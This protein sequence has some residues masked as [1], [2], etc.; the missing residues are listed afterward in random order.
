MSI[1]SPIFAFRFTR[2]ADQ[3]YRGLKQPASKVDVVYPKPTGA[4]VTLL[5]QD[6]TSWMRA[7]RTKFILEERLPA[8]T[9]YE[10]FAKKFVA[11][12]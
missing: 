12:V 3:S 2:L 6:W 8:R 11:A 7:F 4:S 1:E 10:S 5:Q 9:C